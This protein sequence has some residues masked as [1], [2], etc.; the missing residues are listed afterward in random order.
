M[1]GNLLGAALVLILANE[2]TILQPLVHYSVHP[3]KLQTQ[4]HAVETLIPNYGLVNEH[5]VVLLTRFF[6]LYLR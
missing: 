6:S 1:D 3:I 5:L 2:G 4:L